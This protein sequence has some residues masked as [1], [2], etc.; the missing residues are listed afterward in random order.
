M[1]KF[2]KYLLYVMLATAFVLGVVFYFNLDNENMVNVLLY[3][4]YALFALAVF[5]AVVLPLFNIGSNPKA[6]KKI[7]TNLAIVIV[8]CC[9]SYVLASGDAL[10]VSIKP[11]PSSS[12]L[13]LTDAG[14]ILT[15]IVF[16]FSLIAIVFGGIINLIRNR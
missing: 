3:Y 7:F 10:T 14:L 11:E 13:K 16:A 4:G 8:V 1:P 2:V 15:Y 6:L 5:S 12:T 9:L